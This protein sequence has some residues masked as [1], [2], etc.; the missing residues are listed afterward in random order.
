MQNLFSRSSSYWVKYSGYE[1]RK[2]NDGT[3]YITPTAEAK[4]TVYD[5]LQNADQLVLDMLNTGLICMR[6]KKKAAQQDAVLQFVSQYGLLGF[7]TALP[8]TPNFMEYEAVYLPKNHFIKEETLST[9]AYMQF[10]FA[11]TQPTFAKQGI[12]SAWH[13]S[14][15]PMMTALAATFG[16]KPL[17]MSMSFQREYAERFDWLVQQF[18]DW[19][20]T[21]FTSFFYYEDH[22][23]LDEETQR[24]YRESMAAFDGIAP[25]YHIALLDKPTII[26]D[27]HSLLLG[28]QMMFSFLL[29]DD[30]S[31]L[32]ICKGCNKAYIAS[33]SNTA[34]CSATCKNRFNAEKG[35]RKG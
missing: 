24:L 27:F 19:A 11:F 33:R 25:S 4:P 18:K 8:T 31:S 29:T 21:F 23:R 13:V 26:W 1:W 14:G 28:V 7:F 10:F 34:F 35:R 32:R 20:F 17:A 3:L 6:Q 30:K 2:A 22:N 9:S 15:D 16:N 5:P 12:E